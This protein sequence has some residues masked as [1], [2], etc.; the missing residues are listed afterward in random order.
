MLSKC[1]ERGL[2]QE[3]SATLFRIGIT[4]DNS[5]LLDLLPEQL[6]ELVAKYPNDS[7]QFHSLNKLIT[8]K[9]TNAR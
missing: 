1:R 9:E 3:L 7:E 5:E 2:S 6:R 8:D 4:Q